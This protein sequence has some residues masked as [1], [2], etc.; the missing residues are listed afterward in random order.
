MLQPASSTPMVFPRS[1]A[2]SQGLFS[3][4]LYV[5]FCVKDIQKNQTINKKKKMLV[6]K[7]IIMVQ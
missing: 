5:I 3:D 4:I 2:D 6:Q 7:K 1:S